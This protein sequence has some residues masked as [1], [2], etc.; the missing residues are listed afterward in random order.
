MSFI[1]DFFEDFIGI[2]TRE[3]DFTCYRKST[4]DPLILSLR[5]YPRDEMEEPE[6]EYISIPVEDSNINEVINAEVLS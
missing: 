3:D 4:N 2:S 5:D 6:V 1:K